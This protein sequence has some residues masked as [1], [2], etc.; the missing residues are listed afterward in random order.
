MRTHKTICSSLDSMRFPSKSVATENCSL[1]CP[2]QRTLN[3]PD[4]GII[5]MIRQCRGYN[6][7]TA[8]KGPPTLTQLETRGQQMMGTAGHQISFSLLRGRCALT[9]LLGEAV[10]PPRGGNELLQTSLLH[11]KRALDVEEHNRT[12]HIKAAATL[13]QAQ[14][15]HQRRGRACSL[16]RSE[17]PLSNNH[18]KL[19]KIQSPLLLGEGPCSYHSGCPNA[20]TAAGLLRSLFCSRDTREVG[21]VEIKSCV[22]VMWM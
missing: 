20:T 6:S 13:K 3:I 21:Q 16:S 4:K 14:Q 8:L 1:P 2:K 9:H 17:R 11:A 18:S 7:H 22:L 10:W 19:C 5:K 15:L 12:E